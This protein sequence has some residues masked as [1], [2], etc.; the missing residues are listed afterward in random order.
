MADNFCFDEISMHIYQNQVS[1]PE[2]QHSNCG[3]LEFAV[4]RLKSILQLL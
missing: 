2:Y 4:Y 1:Q 3:L